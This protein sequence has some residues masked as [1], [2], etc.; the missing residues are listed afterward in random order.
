MSMM[1]AIG[2]VNAEVVLI[3]PSMEVG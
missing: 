3:I 1:N 2:S